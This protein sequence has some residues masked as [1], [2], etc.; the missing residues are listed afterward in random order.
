MTHE[1]SYALQAAFAGIGIVFGFLVLLSLLMV[2]IR[3]L[4]DLLFRDAPSPAIEVATTTTSAAPPS[5]V[6]AAAVAYLE[7]EANDEGLQA[8]ASVWVNRGNR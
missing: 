4:V 3:G 7:R 1:L 6:V 8:R 5:W 2:A